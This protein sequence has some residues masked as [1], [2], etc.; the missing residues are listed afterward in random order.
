MLL[1]GKTNFHLFLVSTHPARPR[2]TPAR[3]PPRRRA[4]GGRWID[5]WFLLA[6]KINLV[7]LSITGEEFQGVLD[8]F[9]ATDF[10]SVLGGCLPRVLDWRKILLKTG[11][12]LKVSYGCKPLRAMTKVE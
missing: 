3:P 4:L 10:S 5:S 12:G 11:G 9:Y 2:R 7:L 8:A 1:R 6:G